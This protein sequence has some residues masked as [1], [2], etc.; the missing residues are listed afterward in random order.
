MDVA[1]TEGK[2][3]P[4]RLQGRHEYAGQGE[5]QDREHVKQLFIMG[6]TM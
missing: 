3:K 2:D 6:N 1:E 5:V 4:E